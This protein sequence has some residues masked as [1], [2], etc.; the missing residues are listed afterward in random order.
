MPSRNPSPRLWGTGAVTSLCC[1]ARPTITHYRY[2][3]LWFA[4]CTRC[5]L[6]SLTCGSYQ[7][8]LET[9]NERNLRA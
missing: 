8:L 4:W 1:L 6:C 7:E 2:D 9:W 3:D 5:G